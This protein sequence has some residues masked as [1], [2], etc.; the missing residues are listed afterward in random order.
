MAKKIEALGAYRPRIELGSTVQRDELVEYLSSR[1]GINEGLL[2]FVLQEVRDAIISYSR[3]GRGVKLDGLGTYLP[4]IKL[5]GTLN[6]EH[7]LD[8]GI[9]EAL[10]KPRSFSGSIE[11]REH[12][13]KTVEELVKVWNTEHPNDPIE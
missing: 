3:R 11:N 1:T 6:V 8:R 13:G 12:I 5:D 9:K 10:N 7:R 4:N 2:I